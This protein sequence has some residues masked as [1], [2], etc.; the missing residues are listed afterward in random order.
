MRPE[1]ILLIE[2]N[3]DEAALA[4][5]LLRMEMPAVDVLQARDLSAIEKALSSTSFDLVLTGNCFS[6]GNGARVLSLVRRHLPG[7]PVVMLTSRGSEEAARD[8]LKRGFADYIPA[9]A[10]GYL[11]L[12]KRVRAILE[13][14]HVSVSGFL[15][16]YERLLELLDEP[17][18][19]ATRNGLL[20]QVN[21]AFCRLVR[22]SD[23]KAARGR[24]LTDFLQAD[25]LLGFLDDLD[26]KGTPKTA[27]LPLRHG[28][29]VCLKAC[30]VFQG[31]R[32]PT[33]LVGRIGVEGADVASGSTIVNLEEVFDMV[34]DDLLPLAEQSNIKV[35]RGNLPSVESSHLDMVCLFQNLL[36]SLLRLR[37]Q[38]HAVINL[39]AHRMPAEW[40]FILGSD[41]RITA[42]PP[43]SFNTS[44][45]IIERRGGR[46]WIASD[47]GTDSSVC[48]TLPAR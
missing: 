37:G 24:R 25:L 47:S 43:G 1:K 17:V 48:F 44:Q 30:L 18:F 9:N 14:A 36:A 33:V 3:P 21:P 7:C 11:A 46:F 42:A 20:L 38:H 28:P 34:L 32:L 4:L 41:C 23:A 31:D 35:I 39:T 8:A 19:L 22:C 13:G 12:G 26:P 40:L 15:A 45:E 2:E 5:R 10:R 29:T 27:R 6:W 16:Q